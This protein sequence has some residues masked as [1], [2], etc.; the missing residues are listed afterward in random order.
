[1]SEVVLRSID[2][3]ALASPP[4]CEGTS[5]TEGKE[6]EKTANGESEGSRDA[7]E[8]ADRVGKRNRLPIVSHRWVFRFF[9]TF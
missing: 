1:M 4:R 9:I 5:R 6:R 8:G 2:K 3:R 7:R